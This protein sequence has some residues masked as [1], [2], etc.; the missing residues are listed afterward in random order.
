MSE[1]NESRTNAPCRVETKGG[2]NLLWC[3]CGL[4]KRQPFCDFSHKGSGIEPLSFATTEDLTVA[5]C[6]C[7]RTK[8]PPYC[9]GSHAL[10]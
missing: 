9:D 1:K 6:G 2:R 10:P 7:K 5:L 8:R 4:S 3:A